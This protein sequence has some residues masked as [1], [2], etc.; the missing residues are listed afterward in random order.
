MIY[1]TTGEALELLDSFTAPD[2]IAVTQGDLR[3]RLQEFQ[4]FSV[5]FY[6]AISMDDPLRIHSCVYRLSRI[7]TLLEQWAENLMSD[8]QMQFTQAE[9]RING[10]IGLL[11]D[12]LENNLALLKAA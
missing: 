3:A 10:S 7:S 2:Y 1:T 4:D 11:H 6:V 5:D 8:L 9:R 12:E